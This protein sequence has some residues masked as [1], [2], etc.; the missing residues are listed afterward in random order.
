M[1]IFGSI[2]VVI[3]HFKVFDPGIAAHP[4][5]YRMLRVLVPAFFIMS[6]FLCARSFSK[7]RVFRQVIRY[8]AIYL[9]IQF[10]LV[11]WVHASTYMKSGTL[12]GLGVDLLK[13]LVHRHEYARQLWFI[14]ALLYPMLLNA[15]LDSS[16]KR[17]IVIGVAAVFFLFTQT[18]GWEPI[19]QF[20]ETRAAS[21]PSTARFFT[22]VDLYLLLLFYS[23]GLLFTTIGFDISTWKI[24]PVHLLV[25]AVPVVLLEVFVR[26]IGLTP[27]LLS[28]LCFE[29]IKRLPGAWM[30]PY[31]FEISVF[32]G[33]MYFLHFFGIILIQKYITLNVFVGVLLVTAANILITLAASYFVRRRKERAITDMSY[34]L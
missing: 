10:F 29:G 6:G 14:P 5:A 9:A 33:A 31:H 2:L 22:P 11:F 32:S 30:Y 12:S 8:G 23:M 26:Y 28:I 27:I 3:A 4:Q 24:R 20:F 7:E 19:V 16:L 13:A 17:R 34:G 15:F 1:R 25:A 18:V 21:D